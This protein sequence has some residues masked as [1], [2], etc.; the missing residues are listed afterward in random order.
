[1]LEVNLFLGVLSFW[2]GGWGRLNW[3]VVRMLDYMVKYFMKNF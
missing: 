1:M 2:F 3:D